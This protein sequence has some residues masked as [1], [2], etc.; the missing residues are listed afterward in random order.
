VAAIAALGAID[1]VE[2]NK[3][4]VMRRFSQDEQDFDE[5]AL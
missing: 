2:I 1:Q 3:G 4:E 5:N